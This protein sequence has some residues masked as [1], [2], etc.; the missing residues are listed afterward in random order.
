MKHSTAILTNELS[1]LEDVKQAI[2]GLEMSEG[3]FRSISKLPSEQLQPYRYLSRKQ[4]GDLS[5]QCTDLL[6]QS[7]DF[8][9]R[10]EVRYK[11]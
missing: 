7:E 3:V 10:A 1:E 6:R 8:L 2:E 4:C 9:T 11:A 5:S